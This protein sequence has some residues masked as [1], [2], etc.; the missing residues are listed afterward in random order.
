MAIRP[1]SRM[2]RKLAYPRPRTPSRF[3]LGTRT[4]VKVSGWVSEAF[5]PTLLYAGSAVKPGV[6][7]GTMI[8]E[9]SFL[10]LSLWPVTAVTVFDVAGAADGAGGRA[11]QT[12][13][14]PT[15]R[16]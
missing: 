5:H 14:A 7:D 4:S 1:S 8:V 12:P 11:R 16:V 9:I 6:P 13:A 2:D 10:P 3:S 15:N